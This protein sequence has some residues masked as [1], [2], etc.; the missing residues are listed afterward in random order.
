[1]LEVDVQRKCLDWL[2]ERGIFHWRQN[3]A[4][5]PR[6]GGYRRFNG[7]LGVSDI[8]GVLPNGRFLAIEVKQP[9]KKPTVEQEAFLKRVNDLGGVG[10]CVH[11]LYE[12]KALLG[13]HGL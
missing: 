7:L 6:P 8:L 13:Q 3:Q 1:M 10:I 5:V 2:K 4:A 9:G 11:S 12:L